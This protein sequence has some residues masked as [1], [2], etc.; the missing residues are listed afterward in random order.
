MLEVFQIDFVSCLAGFGDANRSVLNSAR[1]VGLGIQLAAQI[2]EFAAGR[3]RHLYVV[4]NFLEPSEEIFGVEW[5]GCAVWQRG[6]GLAIGCEEEVGAA[7][8]VENLQA[9]WGS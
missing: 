1:G 4:A 9:P 5:D 8:E 6:A 2:G 7:G 3:R